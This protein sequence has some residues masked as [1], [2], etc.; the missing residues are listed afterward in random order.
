MAEFPVDPMLAKMIIA[1]EEYKCVDQIITIV[2]M[3]TLG[4]SVFYRPKDKVLHADN[5]K[6]NFFRP[7]GDHIALLNCYN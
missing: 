1:S 6:L 7:G 5:A 4:G 3:L 2:A